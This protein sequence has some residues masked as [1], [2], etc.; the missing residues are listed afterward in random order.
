MKKTKIAI[1]ALFTAVIIL[2]CASTAQ[3][4][5]QGFDSAIENAYPDRIEKTVIGMDFDEFKTIWPEATKKGIGEV[6]EFI[7]IQWTITGI[8]YVYK[9]HTTFYFS[10]NKL[11]KYESTRTYD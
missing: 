3:G 10:D 5:T 4:G 7:H 8:L 11:V 9:A 1:L 6:Y 2:G